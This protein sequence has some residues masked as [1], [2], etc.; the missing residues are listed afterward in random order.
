MI[1]TF[2]LEGIGGQIKENWEE[3][4]GT[5]S[6]VTIR[7]ADFI[8]NVVAT[9]RFVDLLF[10]FLLQQKVVRLPW[11]T[12]ALQQSLRNPTPVSLQL[13]ATD[14][15]HATNKQ[16]NT[17]NTNKHNK[18]M[19]QTS[20]QNQCYLHLHQQQKSTKIVVPTNFQLCSLSRLPETEGQE[21]P[22]AV[23]MK[24]DVEGKVGEINLVLFALAVI[25]SM[26]LLCW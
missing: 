8:N 14:V 2:T 6:A 18:Q 10:V 22:P 20:K 15:F 23:I 26:R 1:I 4:D 19:Y 9:R 16:T 5:T 17:K 11:A 13:K 25:I 24:L 7:I 3:G 21:L 12:F